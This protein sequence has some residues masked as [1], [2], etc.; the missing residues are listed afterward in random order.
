M[1][2][3]A[4]LIFLSTF[5]LARQANAVDDYARKTITTIGIVES[6]DGYFRIAEDWAIDCSRVQGVM[7]YKLNTDFGKMVHSTLLAAKLSGK[8]ISRIVYSNDGSKCNVALLEIE[9]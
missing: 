2:I 1:K 9:N 6:G 3:K 7:N 8:G 5:I 4:I